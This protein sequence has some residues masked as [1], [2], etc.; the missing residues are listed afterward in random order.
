[1]NFLALILR[2]LSG[3]RLEEGSRENTAWWLAGLAVVPP[4]ISSFT[5]IM[6][7]LQNSRWSYLLDSLPGLV[8][9]MVLAGIVF[10]LLQA[11]IIRVF[12]R[13]PLWLLTV[14]LITWS[15]L[16]WLCWVR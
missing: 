12:C 16:A 10:F 2:M 7:R 4:L 3:E 8:A 11:L 15:G 5:G 1:M 14:A 6:T 13:S 9:M